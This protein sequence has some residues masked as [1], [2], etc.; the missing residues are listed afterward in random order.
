MKSHDYYKTL[1]ISKSASKDEIRSAYRK[2]ARKYHPDVN[3]AKNAEDTFKQ[4]NEA[5]DV[6][7]DPEKKKLY[8]TYGHNWDQAGTQ[9]HPEAES[10]YQGHGGP[11]GSTRTFHFSNN[12]DFG[13]E[14]DLNDILRNLF[15]KS[16]SGGFRQNL[17]DNS[18][19]DNN[20]DQIQEAEITIS[21]RDAF[22][23]STKAISLQTYDRG[24]N[25]QFVPVT[26]NLHVNIPKGV[27]NGSIIRLAGQ[28]SGGDLHL[29]I[30]VANDSQ[31]FVDGHDLHT[32]VAVSPWE[33]AL[34]AKIPVHTVEGVVTLT[35]PKGTQHG[36]KFRLRG[37]GL[38]KRKAGAGD[39]IVTLEIRVPEK[40][41]RD[42]EKLFAELAS[43]SHF[44]PRAQQHQRA[45]A[46]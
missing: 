44:N 34:G 19:P 25:G 38:P 20:T 32:S 2:L 27:S 33:A 17:N 30:R 40:L 31:F 18:F 3:K 22:H 21:I 11:K 26:R 41:S 6:L 42:E 46:A 24:D 5:Y 35:I 15:R 28:S 39:L 12:N 13:G 36:K 10:F 23:G 45:K 37:K 8:D 43:K 4:V 14:A 1:G 9:P 16:Q 7:K 29:K